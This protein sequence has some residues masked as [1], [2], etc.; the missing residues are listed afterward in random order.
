M[1]GVVTTRSRAAV[2]SALIHIGMREWPHLMS[3]ELPGSL[4][5]LPSSTPE[6]P[7]AHLIYPAAYL[8]ALQHTST[9][10]PRT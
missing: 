2:A 4:P 10:L 8:K 3:P 6:P 5:D 9:A 1:H 7:A